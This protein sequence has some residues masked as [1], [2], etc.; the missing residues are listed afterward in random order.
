MRGRVAIVYN[1]PDFGRYGAVGEE[2]AVF[3]VLEAVEAVYQ[4]LIELGSE[5]IKLPLRPPLEL[6][7][8]ELRAI[9]TDLVFNL[10]EGF[11][12]DPQTEAMVPEILSEL[13]LAYTGCPPSALRM[14]LD[15]A[16]MKVVLRSRQIPTPDFQVLDP[17]TLP[18]FR[19]DYPCIVKPR[20]EDASHG[21]TPESVVSDFPALARQVGLVS[22]DYG[23][24]ALVEEY[25]DGREFNATVLGDGEYTVL[26]PS[27]IVY[28]LPAG[29]PRI[30]TYAAKWQPETPFFL[31]TRAVCP[32][33]IGAGEVALINQTA[34]AAFKLLGGRGYARVDMRFDRAGRLNV[35]EV[36]PNPDI[37]PGTGAARQSDA[38]GMTYAEFIDKITD[39]AIR[40]RPV[41]EVAR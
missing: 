1:E 32:A 38:A 2:L 30:L 34:V 7:K 17:G 23:G 26:P 35:L 25:I 40:G 20:G 15:K 33:D 10:F 28:S 4:A 14:A 31:G 21:L 41:S 16:N 3:G 29:V 8:E 11:S 13:G 37:S 22:R 27:E 19:L 5:V 18:T 39:M 36:N 24:C 12:D 6:A 9:N